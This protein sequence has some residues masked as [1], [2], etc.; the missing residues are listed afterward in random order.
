M[1]RCRYE[2]RDITPPSDVKIAMDKQ[3]QARGSSHTTQTQTPFLSRRRRLPRAPAC[4]AP[5]R[6]LPCVSGAPPRLVPVAA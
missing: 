2:I 3:A 6:P 5:P 4:D 1:A